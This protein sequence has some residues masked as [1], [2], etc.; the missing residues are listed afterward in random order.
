MWF[1][2]FVADLD[3]Y[4]ATRGNPGACF[5]TESEACRPFLKR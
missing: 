2:A 4:R 5:L 3:R 1:A